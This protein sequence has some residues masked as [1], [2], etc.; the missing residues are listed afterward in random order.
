MTEHTGH[1]RILSKQ[2]LL[3]NLHPGQ[4]WLC[5]R[6]EEDLPHLEHACP[7]C[8]LPL[9]QSQPC[10]HCLKDPPPWQQITAAFQYEF[11]I[12][13]LI[14]RAKYEHQLHFIPLLADLLLKRIPPAQQQIE[15]ILPVP[16]SRRKLRQRH[17]NHAFLL[18]KQ[19]GKQLDIPVAPNAL[20]KIRETGQQ[21]DLDRRVR[22]LN[23]RGSFAVKAQLPSSVAVVDDVI[24]TGSTLAE[25]TG[26]LAGHGVQKITAW[27]VARTPDPW[28]I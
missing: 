25:I 3:C 10:G 11:P 4:P 27:V 21:K 7:H 19:L 26:L 28:L 18:A 24:T 20:V 2:C 5:R 13:E 16:M 6:C 1:N 23:L 22:Q 12:N 8:A 17:V 14:G 15:L 9:S